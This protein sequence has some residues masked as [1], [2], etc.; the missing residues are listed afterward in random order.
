MTIQTREERLESEL[1]AMRGY[2]KR[3]DVEKSELHERLI[4]TAA[5]I[6]TP[7]ADEQPDVAAFGRGAWIYCR[8][9]VKPHLTGWCSCGVYDKIGLG[10]STAKE[11]YAKCE[12]WGLKIFDYN[13][14]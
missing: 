2:M 9:H 1:E 14:K 7:L 8:S 13:K 3:Y 6:N 10:V 12:E 11:A 4:Q 5:L